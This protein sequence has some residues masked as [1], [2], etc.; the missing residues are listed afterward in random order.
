M[1][2]HAEL[3]HVVDPNGCVGVIDEHAKGD[4]ISIA[5]LSGSEPVRMIDPKTLVPFARLRKSLQDVK[6][7]DT[8]RL[9]SPV[10]T[11]IVQYLLLGDHVGDHVQVDTGGLTRR[12]SVAGIEIVKLNDLESYRANYRGPGTSPTAPPTTPLVVAPYTGTLAEFQ[13]RRRQAKQ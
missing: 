13:A 2:D 3:T 12:W 5:Y 8:V 9:L 6:H 11:G 1:P 10:R 4:K 7:G